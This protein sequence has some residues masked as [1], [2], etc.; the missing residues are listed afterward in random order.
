MF[1]LKSIFLSCSTQ[2]K[3]YLMPT[4]QFSAIFSA[5]Q[6]HTEFFSPYSRHAPAEVKDWIWAVKQ[7]YFG[8]F[9][10]SSWIKNPK[11]SGYEGLRWATRNDTSLQIKE[12]WSLQ[13]P[14]K[15]SALISGFFLYSGANLATSIWVYQIHVTGRRIWLLWMLWSTD[16][17]VDVPFLVWCYQLKCQFVKY[18]L[19]LQSRWT[20]NARV[21]KY[22][23]YMHCTIWLHPCFYSIIYAF[24]TAMKKPQKIPRFIWILINTKSLDA[25]LCLLGFYNFYRKF[26]ES[27][28]CSTVV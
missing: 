24:C 21:S 26:G 9:F 23:P 20:G 8:H 15:I 28:F 18:L 5:I 14:E 10:F 13:L 1:C 11:L 3:K 2:S 12:K 25:F 22:L 4:H 17:C 6:S 19:Y 7:T 27:T 16:A